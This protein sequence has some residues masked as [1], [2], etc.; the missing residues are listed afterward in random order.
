VKQGTVVGNGKTPPGVLKKAVDPALERAFLGAE[1]LVGVAYDGINS[2]RHPDE[3]YSSN[4]GNAGHP[5]F[6]LKL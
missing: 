5:I 6:D 3:F 2:I 4:F 1:V